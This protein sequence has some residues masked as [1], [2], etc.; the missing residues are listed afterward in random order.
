MKKCIISN[1]T[2][3]FPHQKQ[4]FFT[5][6][7]A[8]FESGKIYFIQ[9]KNGAGKSTFF[10]LLQGTVAHQS[11][12]TG[13]ITYDNHDYPIKNNHIPD[14]ISS[15]VKTV[16]QDSSSMIADDMSVEKNMQLAQLS[17]HPRFVP[18]PSLSHVPHLIQKFN[19]NLATQ[20]RYL[21]GGQ[22]QILAI[23]MALQKP[24]HILLLDEPTAALDEKNSILVMDFLSTLAREQQ[25]I[26]LVITHDQDIVD[27]YGAHKNITIVQDDQGIRTIYQ[28]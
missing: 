2:F 26:I 20:A 3:T 13:S 19:L 1:L 12:L 5:H 22:K 28:K 8:T 14:Q 6:I 16:V 4:P 23:I 21:S 18:L 25:L 27:T 7:N 10:S 9:G 15:F 17:A 11:E 24:T